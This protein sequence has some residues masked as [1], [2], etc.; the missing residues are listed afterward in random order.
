[1]L[2]PI[3]LRILIFSR[4]YWLIISWIITIFPLFRSLFSIFYQFDEFF[5]FAIFGSIREDFSYFHSFG[6]GLNLPWLIGERHCILLDITLCHLFFIDAPGQVDSLPMHVYFPSFVP[7]KPSTLMPLCFTSADCLNI[8]QDILT[9]TYY[10][11]TAPNQI[12]N[13]KID[14]QI[15]SCIITV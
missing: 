12:P 3:T 11:Q 8:N 14:H 4:V 13:I 7:W 5:L 2:L 10:N 6:Y 9:E 15:N 1:M